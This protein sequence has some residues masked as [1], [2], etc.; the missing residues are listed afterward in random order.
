MMNFSAI[1]PIDVVDIWPEIAP[2]LE[3]LLDQH[4][5]G[6]WTEPDVLEKLLAG[7]WQL[8]IVLDENQIIACLI[9]SILEGHKKTLEIGLCWGADAQSWTGEVSAAF[10]QIA[11]E[12]GCEQLALDGRPGWRNMAHKLGYKLD[13]VRYTRQINGQH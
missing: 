11:R 1:S 13:S 7:E 6:R 3:D 2:G 9:C 10:E 8:F 5:L 12:M 4:T